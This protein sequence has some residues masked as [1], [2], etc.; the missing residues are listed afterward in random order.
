MNYPQTFE[1]RP[2]LVEVGDGGAVDVLYVVVL[3]AVVLHVV[4]LF[5]VVVSF[6]VVPSVVVSFA[7]VLFVVALFAVVLFVAGLTDAQRHAVLRSAE[8][9]AAHLLR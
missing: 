3:F 1:A 4:V 2:V 6:A 9:S 7:V 8:L 5:A